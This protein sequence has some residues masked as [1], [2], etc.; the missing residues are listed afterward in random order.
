M[1]DF[2]QNFTGLNF[3][4]YDPVIILMF[5]AIITIIIFNAFYEILAMFFHYLLNRR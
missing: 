2:L 1:Y 3:T 4:D 5:I